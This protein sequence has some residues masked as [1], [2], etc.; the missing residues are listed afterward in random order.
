MVAEDILSSKHLPCA[1]SDR[2]VCS[3]HAAVQSRHTQARVLCARPAVKAATAP[4]ADQSL[5]KH[6]VHLTKQF[7]ADTDSKDITD[8]EALLLMEEQSLRARPGLYA[9]L[10][11]NLR[12]LRV[13]P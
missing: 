12:E 7:V 9:H 2:H 13:R 10:H 1:T 5:L 11:K 6:V 4:K 8:D 3:C